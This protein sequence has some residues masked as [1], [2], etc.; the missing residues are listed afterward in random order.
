MN[1]ASKVEGR[2]MSD[3][4]A[5]EKLRSFLTWYK[6]LYGAEMYVSE[7][8]EKF[9][10]SGY[11]AGEGGLTATAT[12]ELQSFRQ[13]ICECT[14]CSLHRSRTKFVFGVGNENANIMFVGEAPG[15]D[16]DLQG[17][18]FVGRAGKLLNKLLEEFGLV[19]SDVYIANI[20]KCR[21][22]QN[23]DPLPEEVAQCIP[24]LHR[25]I[26]LIKPKILV[27]LGRIAAQNLLNTKEALGKMRLRTW[28]YQNTPL[29]VTYHPAAILRNM[30]LIDAARA[31][32][33]KIIDVSRSS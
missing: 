12:S 32:F 26:E 4:S 18:P 31:D 11:K 6:D 27:A 21:P 22:P 17:E 16:E 10:S 19:R 23:R 30:G 8:A 5:S 28:V 15:R 3:R 7:T 14:K 24:Y 33:K 29:I 20:L 2:L 25:Q 13:E 1:I 9:M